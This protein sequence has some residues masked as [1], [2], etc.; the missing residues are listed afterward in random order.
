MVLAVRLYDLQPSYFYGILAAGLALYITK[1]RHVNNLTLR[2]LNYKTIVYDL[3]MY[4][5][6]VAIGFGIW[7]CIYAL[8]NAVDPAHFRRL[9]PL[10]DIFYAMAQRMV[11]IGSVMGIMLFI[12]EGGNH[13]LNALRFTNKV[14]VVEVVFVAISLLWLAVSMNFI[15]MFISAITVWTAPPSIRG[16]FDRACRYLFKRSVNTQNPQFNNNFPGGEL[17]P[18]D[19]K[20]LL[21]LVLALLAMPLI[22]GIQVQLPLALLTLAPGTIFRSL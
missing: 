16:L 18:V 5:Y 10:D 14:W 6:F 2:E 19:L 22:N 15:T 8:W 4:A 3:V 17:P 7:E 13:T 20:G 11:M 1:L 21:L 12:S 9:F